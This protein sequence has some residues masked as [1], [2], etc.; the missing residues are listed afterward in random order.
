MN[1]AATYYSGLGVPKDMV[2]AYMW[3]ALAQ[4]AGS[5]EA[6]R[7]QSRLAESMTGEEISLAQQFVREWK[8]AKW[9]EK[10]LP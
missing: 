7:W 9:D 8:A 1:L 3:Y 2:L 10:P 5:L 4:A 6:E